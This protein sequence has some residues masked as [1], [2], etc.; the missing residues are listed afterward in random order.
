M[1]GFEYLAFAGVVFL[2]LG[3]LFY[4]R[5]ERIQ[6]VVNEKASVVDVRAATPFN[7]CYLKL[8]IYTID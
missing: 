7:Q 8:V 1:G 3:A 2:G 5:G 6:E 4:M